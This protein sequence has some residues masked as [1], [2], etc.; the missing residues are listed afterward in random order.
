MLPSS[1][2]NRDSDLSCGMQGDWEEEQVC[3]PLFGFASPI[4]A[5]ELENIADEV[6]GTQGPDDDPRPPRCRFIPFS[7]ALTDFH[8]VLLVAL[9]GELLIT[10]A[11][12]II[13]KQRSEGVYWMNVAGSRRSRSW[14]MT[15]GVR[16]SRVWWCSRGG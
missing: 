4:D 8:T 15:Q 13:R 3:P 14:R 11:S 9:L 7:K 5:D 6:L 12:T 2:H 16:T 1:N 10:D